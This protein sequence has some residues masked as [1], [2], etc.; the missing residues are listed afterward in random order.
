MTSTFAIDVTHIRDEARQHLM[1]GPVTP[2]N[3]T[4]VDRVITVLNQ[5]LASEMV[6]YLRY[7]QNAIVAQGIDREQVA[8]MFQDHAAEELVHFKRVSD[9]INQLGG[10]PDMNPAS[11]KERAITEYSVPDDNSD[12]QGMIRENL[13]AE[14]IV[15]E[16][17]TEIIRWLGDADITS[18]R[19]IEDILKEEEDHADELTDLYA[20]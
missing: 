9:R 17:Y 14:R 11:M 15:I 2:S 10:S 13:L 18:R 1:Q 8:S 6:C 19:L 4:D 3:T 20:G 12:L 16:S 5:V 7:T